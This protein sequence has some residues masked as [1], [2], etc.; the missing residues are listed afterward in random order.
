[1]NIKLRI[2]TLSKAR[3]PLYHHL[4]ILI[5]IQVMPTLLEVG[6]FKKKM[7]IKNLSQPT[8]G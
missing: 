8:E 3:A 5:E 7:Q 2:N 6:C 1:M 4:G